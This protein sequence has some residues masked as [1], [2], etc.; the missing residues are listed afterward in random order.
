[1]RRSLVERI[2]GSCSVVGTV[3][4]QVP[5]V[6]SPAETHGRPKTAGEVTGGTQAE[7]ATPT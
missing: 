7:S 6:P 3:R 4:S 1:M 5:P 2:P